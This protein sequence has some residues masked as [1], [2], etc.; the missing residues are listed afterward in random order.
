M[1]AGSAGSAS[2]RARGVT[3]RGARAAGGAADARPIARSGAARAEVCGAAPPP[4]GGAHQHTIPTTPRQQC[5]ISSPASSTHTQHT[6]RTSRTPPT[7]PPRPRPPPPQ[8]GLPRGA[9]RH[10]GR[11]PARR[12]APAGHPG[13]GAQAGGAYRGG[14]ACLPTHRRG[15]GHPRTH[16]RTHARA[17]VRAC[18]RAGDRGQLAVWTGSR[19]GGQAGGRAHVLRGRARARAGVG[20]RM[21][22]SRA[23]RWAQV[24]AWAACRLAV[25]R[26]MQVAVRAGVRVQECRMGAPHLSMERATPND[27][28]RRAVI[29][30]TQ[31]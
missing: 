18:P 26:P 10:A 16:A 1:V 27:G 23:G 3:R 19:A 22:S 14:L 21:G 9:R 5:T 29:Q 20:G 15:A 4:A 7:T 12:A 31:L 17:C 6:Q 24:T 2:S 8:P 13:H 11:R 30:W 28:A 25:R